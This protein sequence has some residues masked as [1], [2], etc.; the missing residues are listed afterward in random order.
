VFRESRLLLKITYQALVDMD[1]DYEQVLEQG[2]FDKNAWK[3][4][5]KA[6]RFN[7]KSHGVFWPILEQVSGDPYIGLHLAE[8][9][10]A[11]TSPIHAVLILS[12]PT[13]GIGLERISKYLCLM[14][15]AFETILQVNEGK[16]EIIFVFK[17]PEMAKIRH[18]ADAYFS[19]SI[20]SIKTLTGGQFV[21]DKVYL[22]HDGGENPGEY[23]RAFGCEVAFNAD[24]CTC[25]FAA[26]ILDKPSLM[27]EPDLFSA[28]EKLADQQIAK[29]K[30]ADTVDKVKK[31]I[32]GNLEIGEVTLKLV[33]DELA[34]TT[35]QLRTQLASQDTSLSQLVA[36]RREALSKYLLIQTDESIDQIVYLTGFSE[37]STFY[38][39]FKRW[40]GTTPVVFRDQYQT[41]T[42]IEIP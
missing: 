9:I 28:H 22:N 35:N 39:A 14:S 10:S 16:A 20:M 4:G 11:H 17:D 12:S 32:A 40:T 6:E 18:L 2:G 29:L 19:H 1:V 25:T 5:S 23:E 33:A 15:E 24:T 42:A 36:E 7:H 26:N 27:A 3:Q 13:I 31:V 21:P 38:R 8:N 30:V 34:M 37:P 41:K